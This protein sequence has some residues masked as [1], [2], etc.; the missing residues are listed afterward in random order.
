MDQHQ[1]NFSAVIDTPCPALR[2]GIHTTDDALE[3]IEF[4]PAKTDT[5]PASNSFTQN[6][7]DQLCAYFKDA[8]ALFDI[9]ITTSG[10][11]YQ[12]QVW[13]ALRDIPAGNTLQYGELAKQL[14]S[15]AR[16]I[17]NACRAN[18]TPII[19]PCHRIV[20]AN[21]LGGFSGQTSHSAK[22]DKLIIKRWLINHEHAISRH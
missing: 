18:P 11:P 3:T 22:Q 17:G 16:A 9:D 4:L 13:Q 20:A 5:Q 19:T 8:R 14:S 2:L 6:I 10:T 7:T 21:G 1:Q 15:S 12:Q